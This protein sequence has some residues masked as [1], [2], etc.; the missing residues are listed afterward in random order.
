MLTVRYR[1]RKLT[2]IFSNGV[3][4]N[5][6]VGRKTICDAW[7]FNYKQLWNPK[8]TVRLRQGTQLQHTQSI[9][10]LGQPIWAVAVTKNS[11]KKWLDV[12]WN[13]GS[14]TSY[15]YVWLRD[16]CQCPACFH[17]STISRLVPMRDLDPEIQPKDAVVGE[18]WNLTITWPDG[19]QTTCTSEWLRER[20]FNET[21]REK[22]LEVFGQ[23]HKHWGAEMQ[24]N[25]PTFD[26]DKITSSDDAN[27][28]FLD[29]LTHMDWFGLAL[30]RNAP[31][32]TTGHLRK[33]AEKICFPRKTNYGE[34]FQVES[35]T[36]PSNTAY[37]NRNL[38]YHSDLCNYLHVP[39]VQFLHCLK[40]TSTGGR[41]R[42]VDATNAAKIMENEYPE[43]YKLL[44]EQT[45][46]HRY[47][48]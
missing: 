35:K 4:R 37:T 40:N 46:L 11:V 47:R 38:E 1:T 3:P 5:N 44:C 34:Y 24:D 9:S 12:T 36:N 42:F 6:V 31:T 43:Y 22:R 8:T 7:N 14:Q 2:R 15:P 45:R 16:N 30:M 18:D 10:G 27:P 39:G 23:L 33:I 17:P 19:H 29:W 32:E 25:I 26:Y 48:N 20:S 13:D 41:N 21:A 28:H